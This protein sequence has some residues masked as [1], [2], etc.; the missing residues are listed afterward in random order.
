MA[1]KFVKPANPN[2]KLGECELKT[3][4]CMQAFQD[5]LLN[6][7]MISLEKYVDGDNAKVK[8]NIRSGMQPAQSSFLCLA[9]AL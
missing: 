4:S 8:V 6:E 7:W 2:L 1:D 3:V 5:S 9:L